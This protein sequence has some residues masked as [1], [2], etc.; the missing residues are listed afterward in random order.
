MLILLAVA[1]AAAAQAIPPH[2]IKSAYLIRFFDYITWEHEA[3]IRTFRIGIVGDDEAIFRELTNAAKTVKAKDKPISVARPQALAEMAGFEM[4]FVA[5]NAPFSVREIAA[6]TRRTNTLIVTDG[7]NA[8]RDFMI[9]LVERTDKT[10]GFE[11]N[12]SNIVFERLKIDI[13]I[14]VLGGTELDVAELVKETEGE[15]TQAKEQLTAR[16]QDLQRLQKDVA[17]QTQKLNEQAALIARQTESISARERELA[18]LQER[19][20]KAGEALASNQS[21]VDESQRQLDER[22]SE[23]ARLSQSIG[24]NAALLEKQKQEI[25]GQDAMLATQSRSLERQDVTIEQQ[26]AWLFAAVVALA[27]FI[28]LTGVILYVN[29]ERRKAH[30]RL[31]EAKEI[32]ERASAI[33]D[34]TLRSM[35]QGIL[36]ADATGRILVYNQRLVEYVG[37]DPA[38]AAA[39]TTVKELAEL[40]RTRIGDAAT[41]RALELAQDAGR[42]SYE[43]ETDGRILD[44]RQSQLVDGGFIRTYTDISARKRA[45]EDLRQ[46]QE[47]LALAM[48]AGRFTPWEAD[49]GSGRTQTFSFYERVLRY[50]PGEFEDT[51]ESWKSVV[52]PDDLEPFGSAFRR[53]LEGGSPTFRFQYRAF[54][55][56]RN[57]RWVE[58]VGTIV[59][60]DEAGRPVRIIGTQQD[61]TERRAVEMLARERMR[62]LEEFNRVAVGRELRMIE[63]KQQINELLASLGRDRKYELV[64]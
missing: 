15:M 17:A 48:Q 2:Q 64:E 46:S 30:A 42:T 49:L 62:E 39:C 11:V 16:E 52:H 44:V 56:D 3:D 12:R 24:E 22:L 38:A 32:A 20:Q 51:L 61:V 1:S 10:I 29:R 8:K 25:A 31:S 14:L 27:V 6:A 23:I 28:A 7:S 35:D 9:N 36:M 19:L 60:R 34:T 63:L 37:I 54:D 47:R 55:K 45:E 33:A 13:G 18:A 57:E 4:L 40:A 43:L 41:R 59:E 21:K 26:R 5:R 58:A 50:A 53:F